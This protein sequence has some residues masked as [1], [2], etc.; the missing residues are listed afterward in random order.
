MFQ[1]IAVIPAG[2]LLDVVWQVPVEGVAGMGLMR[3][4]TA[5]RHKHMEPNGQPH[6]DATAGC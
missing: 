5:L 4:W 2:Q 6:H 3:S 1:N